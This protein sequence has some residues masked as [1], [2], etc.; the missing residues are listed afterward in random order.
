MVRANGGRKLERWFWAALGAA[1]ASASYGQYVEDVTVTASRLASVPVR[2]AVVLSREDIA[3]LPVRSL[4][5]LV[6]LVAGT[7]IARRG[8]FGVQADAALRGTTFEGVLVVVDGVAVNDP[9]TGHFHLDVP[10]PLESIEKVEVLTGPA[11]ALFGAGAAGGVLAI[12]TR[13]PREP[14][15]GVQTGDHS[16]SG[17]SLSLPVGTRAGLAFCRQESRGFRPDADFMT[18]LASASGAFDHGGWHRR[19]LFSLGAKQFGAWTFYSSRFPH[20]RERTATGL[21]TFAVERSLHRNL[22]L[23]LRGGFRQHRDVY[24]LDK[25]RPF[26][27]R[28]RHRSR[29][30]TAGFTLSGAQGPF[31]WALGAEGER[32]WLDSSRLGDH[33]SDRA[34]VY[35]EG[36]LASGPFTW[37]VQARQDWL[38]TGNR[39]SPAAGIT[40]AAPSGVAWTVWGAHSFRLPSFTELYYVSPASIGNPRLQPERAWTWES[41]ILIPWRGGSLRLSV[42]HRQNRGLIDWVR[43]ESGVFHATNLPSGRTRGFELDW[44]DAASHR[45]SLAYTDTRFPVPASRSAYALAH[46][47]WEASVSAPIRLGRWLLAPAGTYRKPQQRGGFFLLDLEA[48]WDVR[49]RVSVSV[50]LW[51]ALDRIYEEVPGVPQPGRWVAAGLRWR[52]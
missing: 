12:T 31:S 24:T 15:V 43:A 38:A 42:F 7:G 40:W 14:S 21:L 30:G 22:N 34:G 28:N 48:R 37:H 20:Q 3:R 8:P 33:R 17:F 9:Q 4:E 11:S 50:F 13:Q 25:H 39:F 46:P 6:R 51:N 45:L 1:A 18:T 44:S 16:L 52:P 26:W 41:A 23:Q 49:D 27:Y 19:W 47:R 5:D 35:A 10:I 36:S 29:L 32:A 2:R